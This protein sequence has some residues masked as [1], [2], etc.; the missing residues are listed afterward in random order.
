MKKKRKIDFYTIL[1]IS[2]MVISMIIFVYNL[3][4]MIKK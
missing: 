2:V 3:Y 1:S 4:I